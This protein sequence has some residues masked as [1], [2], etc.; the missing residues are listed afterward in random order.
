MKNDIFFY[1]TNYFI[2]RTILLNKKFYRTK[3]L[4]TKNFTEQS[5]SEKTNEID[6]KR[7]IILRT[8]EINVFERLKKPTEMSRLRTMKERNKK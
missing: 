5:F 8:N 6:G 1:C 7:T 4:L 2:K 3:N